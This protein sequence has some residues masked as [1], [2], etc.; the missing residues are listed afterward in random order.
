MELETS[1]NNTGIVFNI[2]KFSLQ[3]GPGIRTTVFLKGCPL[4]CPWCSN[5][6]SQAHYPEI[7]VYS[8]RCIGCH[9]CVEICPNNA[10]LLKEDRVMNIDRNKCDLCY[11][12]T[13]ACPSGALELTGR[14]MTV[15]EVIKEVI[16]DR[17][18]YSNSGGG[19]TFSGGEPLAQPGF[20]LGL[21]KEAKKES[22]HT[23]LD[24][25]GHAPWE[26]IEKILDYVDLVLYDI[27]HLDPEA[28]LKWTGVKSDLIVK[29]LERIAATGKSEIWVRLPVIPGVND[30]VREMER[31]K[32]LLK[33]I[34]AEKVSL[35]PYH[36][37]GSSKYEKLGLE[38]SLK[39]I[40]PLE[41]EEVEWIKN[42][43]KDCAVEV[44]VGS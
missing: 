17:L 16:Q 8:I 43:M 28:H 15:S 20:L 14:S 7:M 18:F 4:N 2:Q 34:H 13:E 42:E 36:T 23:A 31:L 3:D 27:K 11:Q 19:V 9:S 32:V 37:W 35:L 1:N 22:L 40:Q 21:L 29:N 25:S 5:P 38:Y 30:T 26:H 33:R 24:T 41:E 10:I 39:E 12:C 44:D 6:E